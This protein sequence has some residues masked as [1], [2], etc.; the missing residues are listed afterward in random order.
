MRIG[1]DIVDIERIEMVVNRTPNFLR[2]VFS[3]Q[4]LDY[5]FKKHTPYPS[6]AARFAA[7]EAFRKLDPIFSRGLRFHDVEVVITAGG[8]PE[9]LL[10]SGALERAEEIGMNQWDLSLS[11][12]RNQAIAAVIANKG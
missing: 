5:C 2:R 10:H 4:E 7:K 11:H 1:V 6:L 9:L 3:R 12:S 8:R